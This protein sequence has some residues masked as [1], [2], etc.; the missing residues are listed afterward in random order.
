MKLH[1]ATY[2]PYGVSTYNADGVQANYLHCYRSRTQRD[3]VVE[4]NE[5]DFTAV[6]AGDPIVLRCKRAAERYGA[7]DIE[8][9]ISPDG[10]PYHDR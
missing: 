6:L 4:A 5:D 2:N 8:Q 9:W 7:T 10:W 1:Y 3:A